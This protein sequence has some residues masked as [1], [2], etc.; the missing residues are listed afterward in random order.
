MTVWLDSTRRHS[1]YLYIFVSKVKHM[2]LLFRWSYGVTLWEIITEGGKPYPGK[3]TLD[4]TK[5]LLTGHRMS[6]PDNCDET[7]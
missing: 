7:M 4:L 5:L 2:E 6:K 1:I 3:E